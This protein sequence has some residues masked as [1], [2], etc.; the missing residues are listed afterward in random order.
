MCISK[1][2]RV[3]KSVARIFLD[4]SVLK[5]S[6]DSDLVFVPRTQK[7]DWG[8]DVVEV[9][10]HDLMYKNQ[11]TAYLRNNPD[12]FQNRLYNRLIARLAKD[13]HVELL[14]SHEV[15]F[16]AMGVPSV[17]FSFF[18]SPMQTV[19]SPAVHGG[20][21]I[22]GSGRNHLYDAL[23]SLKHKRFIELQKLTG[24]Y[25]GANQ[26]PNKNQLFDAYHLWSAESADADFLLTH[27]GKLIRQWEGSK[28]KGHSTPI[29]AIALIRELLKRKFWLFI[30]ML[31]ETIKVRL[32]G[33]NLWQ[34]YQ[35][36]NEVDEEFN[37]KHPRD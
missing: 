28:Y 18:G 20:C 14:I 15:K 5:A 10:V 32:S 2:Q 26:E 29:D 30:P 17:D 35:S 22:D 31:K 27:D 19:R 11:N 33:R 8:T 3:S 37:E 12:A 36:Y 7:L 23:R 9:E 16:E 6:K 24:A 25:Q 34:K 1:R 4:T 21:V 13:G